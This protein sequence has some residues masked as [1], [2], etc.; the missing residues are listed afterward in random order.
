MGV[1][2]LGEKKHDLN[3]NFPRNPTE[4]SQLLGTLAKL[5]EFTNG[6]GMSICSFIRMEQLGSRWRDF[7]GI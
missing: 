7:H 2:A 4:W 1:V 3:I 5:R 6:F